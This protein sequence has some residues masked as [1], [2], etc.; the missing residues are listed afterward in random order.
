M[1]TSA[2]A[3]AAHYR[4]TA[5]RMHRCKPPCGV[6]VHRTARYI[7]ALQHYH[8]GVPIWHT[9]SVMELFARM[10]TVS[11]DAFA[12]CKLS[13]AQQALMQVGRQGISEYTRVPLRPVGHLQHLQVVVM[14]S[15]HPCERCIK[16]W[17]T[18]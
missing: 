10:A 18:E 11:A 3:R 13:G 16:H 9:G 8:R 5:L 7:L 17:R 12:L 1:R 2:S 15:A 4:E 14:H 6:G